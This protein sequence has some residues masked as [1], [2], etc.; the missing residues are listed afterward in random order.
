MQLPQGF[1]LEQSTPGGLKLPP[2]FELETSV[3]SSGI[4]GPRRATTFAEGLGRTA[5]SLADVT[6]GGVL[7]AAVQTIGYPVLRAFGQSPEQAAA[8]TQRMTEQVGSPFGRAFGVEKTPEYQGEAARR[9]MEFVGQNIQKGTKWISEQTGVPQQDVDSMAATL[10]LGAP[11]A[12]RAMGQGLR[13][14]AES[15]IGQQ[16]RTG[17]RMPVEPMLEARRQRRSEESY[18]RGPQIDAAKDAQ[19]LKL[20]LNPTDIESSMGARASSTMAG[21]RGEETIQLANRPKVNEIAR[22]DL[23]LPT[24]TQFNGPQAFEAART[25]VAGPYNEIRKIPNI[26]ANDATRAALER[27]R[28]AETLIGG[29]ATAT[30]LNKLIDSALQQLDAGMSGAAFI[31][32]ISKL[33]KD[34]RSIHRNKSAGPDQ[35]DLADTNLAVANVLEGMLE[36]NIFNPTL[37]QQYQAARQQ[38]AKSYV[39]EAATDFNT[40][41]VDPTKIAR[42]TSKD[43]ALTGDLAAIGRIAGN[44]PGAFKPQIGAPWYSTKVSRAGFGGAGGAV[45]GGALGGMGGMGLEGSIIGSAL[46][47]VAGEFGSRR[48]ASRIASPEYQASL[49]VQDFRLP[50]NQLAAEMPQPANALV[51]Y[52]APQS[53]LIPGEGAFVTGPSGP[54]LRQTQEGIYVAPTPATGAAAAA[55][56]ARFVGPQSGPPQ[57]PAPS[58]EA[59]MAGLRAEDARRAGVSRAIGQEAEGRQAAAEAA[60]RRPAGREVMLEIDPATGRMREASQGVRGAT[61][62]T[63][64][65]FGANLQSAA[66]KVT[67][68]RRFDLTAAEKVAWERT[69]VDLAEVSPGFKALSD[70]AIAEKMMDRQWVEAQVIKTREKI[71]AFDEIARRAKDA[72]ARQKAIADRTRLQYDVLA[73]LE[74]LEERLSGPRPTSAGGQGPK[75][76]AAKAAAQRNALTP[77]SSNALND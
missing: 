39:Y 50:Q 17:L 70:K 28:P 55:P 30:K 46:G 41:F 67:A 35:I 21:A 34:A 45:V 11:Q 72:Q 58:A 73:Q 1:V 54:T 8:S 13:V 18:A 76:R 15:P 12:A 14:A 47:G 5:A 42:I 7:P 40:G 26:Q 6:V 49:R 9:L 65:N 71:A 74:A 23:G 2:G 66:E 38:M 56:Q 32:N 24:T 68:G 37:R 77:S 20:A 51:P 44:F 57:L 59:T 31:D 48:M 63:F 69:K 60:A 62:E 19:R 3:G 27:L 61:P 10:T 64:Q 75:T 16:V 52:V 43:N 53:I 25:A 4:P 22:R 33:R 29:E 36:N